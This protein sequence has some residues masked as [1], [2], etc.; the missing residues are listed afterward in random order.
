MKRL[1]LCTRVVACSQERLDGNLQGRHHAGQLELLRHVR[2]QNAKAANLLAQV[3]HLG[4][5]A[6]EVG[7]VCPNFP[8]KNPSAAATRQSA[9]RR[10]SSNH[11]WA[12]SRTVSGHNAVP[13]GPLADV[14]HLHDSIQQAVHRLP[15]A[16]PQLNAAWR[17]Q[18]GHMRHD[19]AAILAPR[20]RRRWRSTE[21]IDA[22]RCARRRRL[23]CRAGQRPRSQI[24]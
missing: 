24:S 5:P 16:P 2:M 22:G 10:R 21:R 3:Q 13:V 6:R 4:T 18:T 15:P 11:G 9:G 17:E 8:L 20:T 14:E 19:S 12:F 1:S 23:W 7:R